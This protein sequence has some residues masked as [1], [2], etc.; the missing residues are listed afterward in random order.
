MIRLPSTPSRRLRVAGA[1]LL[2]AGAASSF[3][4]DTATIVTS[5]LSPGSITGTLGALPT[6]APPAMETES[7][8]ASL[9][10][11][12]LLLIVEMMSM[13]SPG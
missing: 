4:L 5:A 1:S 13:L 7:V 8:V 12:P 2:L 6:R 9:G 10:T 11:S 3:A